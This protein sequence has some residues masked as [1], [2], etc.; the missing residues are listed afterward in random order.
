[1]QYLFLKAIDSVF[2]VICF[3]VAENIVFTFFCD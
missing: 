1:M 3:V 2:E